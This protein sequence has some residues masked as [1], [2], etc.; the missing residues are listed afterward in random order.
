M[1]PSI[2]A[3][4]TIPASDVSPKQVDGEAWAICDSM[5]HARARPTCA[6]NDVCPRVIA[7]CRT[8]NC[9]DISLANVKRTLVCKDANAGAKG[10]VFEEVSSS[11]VL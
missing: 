8:Y 3:S 4:R 6:Q 7:D 2:S 5:P 9:R 10:T 11:V 1:R